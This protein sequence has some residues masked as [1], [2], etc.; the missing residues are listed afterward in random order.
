MRQTLG[1]AAAIGT[2]ALMTGCA[3]PGHSGAFPSYARSEYHAEGLAPTGSHEQVELTE[4]S[5]LNSYLAHAAQNNP[6]LEAA[7]N[8]WKAALERVPQVKAQIGRAHV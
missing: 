3:T 8:R 1:I 5:G 6:G 4:D 2:V 7:F